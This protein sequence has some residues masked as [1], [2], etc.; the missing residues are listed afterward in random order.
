[1][2]NPFSG[3]NPYLEQP[4]YRSDFQNQFVAGI[5]RTLVPKLVTKYRAVNERP[6]T[7]F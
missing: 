5:A 4:E 1:M 2:P 7:W 3:M 6:K